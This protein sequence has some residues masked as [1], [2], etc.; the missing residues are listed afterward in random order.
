[1]NE[2]STMALT[3]AGEGVGTALTTI[4]GDITSTIAEVAPIAVG[5]VGV[6]LIWKF[7]MKFFKS[8]SKSA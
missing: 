5:I 6:F 2:V 3:R 4:A 7:G 1:M 8:L